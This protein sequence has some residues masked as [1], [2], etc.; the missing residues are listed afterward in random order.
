MSWDYQPNENINKL[1]SDGKF[2]LESLSHSGKF[3]NYPRYHGIR[4]ILA[5]GNLKYNKILASVYVFDCCAFCWFNS[6]F[7][8]RNPQW[9]LSETGIGIVWLW[10]WLWLNSIFYLKFRSLRLHVDFSLS[11]ENRMVGFVFFDL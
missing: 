10:L 4:M 1:I 11:S 9:N 6:W 8:V 7:L 3:Q 2:W 5:L